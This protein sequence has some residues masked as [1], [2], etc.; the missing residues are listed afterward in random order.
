MPTKTTTKKSAGSYIET[1]GRRKEAVARVRLTPS[2][3]TGYT[4][5]KKELH[6]FFTTEELRRIVKAPM[7]LIGETTFEVSIKTSGGGM[8]GQAE[9]AAMGIARGIEKHD[10]SMRTVLKKAKHLSRN[11]RAK[12]RRKFGLKKARKS[13]QWSKR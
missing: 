10:T 7:A 9:A 1:V 11:P 4:V 13:P 12:E 6:E 5:N 8:R 3:K 2:K